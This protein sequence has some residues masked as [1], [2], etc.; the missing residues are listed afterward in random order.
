[1]SQ[2]TAF[3]KKL[4]SHNGVGK[5][6]KPWTAYSLKLS[7][8]DGNELEPW[9]QCGFKAPTFAG[10]PLKEGDYVRLNGEVNAKGAV[11]V[12]LDSIKV[13]KNPPARAAEAVADKPKSGGGSYNSDVQRADRAYHAAR[14]TA[15]DLISVLLEQNSLPVAAAQG[16]AGK[17]KRYNEILAFLDKLTV[18]FFRDEFVEGYEDTFRV[19][20]EVADAGIEDDYAGNDL[21]DQEGDGDAEFGDDDFDDTPVTQ[22]PTDDGF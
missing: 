9:F 3:I 13:S 14:G 8:V 6:G 10:N 22:E 19:L 5:T 4:S 11:A 20:T 21:P 15:V 18:Q 1:M 16:K 2:Y 12:D 17:A 7:D